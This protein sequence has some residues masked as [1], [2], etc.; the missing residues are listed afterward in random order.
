[1]SMCGVSVCTA[2][3]VAAG[4]SVSGADALLAFEGMA[5][6]AS[7]CSFLSFRYSDF[8]YPVRLQ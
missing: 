4:A 8:R 7:S 2:V 1:M 6:V 3:A 5:A